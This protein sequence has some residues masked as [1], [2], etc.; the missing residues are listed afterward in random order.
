MSNVFVL[1]N[2]KQPL[3]QIHRRSP[4]R[5]LLGLFAVFKKGGQFPI[6]S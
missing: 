5:S 3:A 1:D 4:G 6:A 2:E